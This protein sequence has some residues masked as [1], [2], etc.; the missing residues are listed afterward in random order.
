MKKFVSATQRFLHSEACVVAIDC[1]LIA[2]LIVMIVIGSVQAVGGGLEATLGELSEA[3][4]SA[5]P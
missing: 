2:A 1:G 3:L 4:T 5:I